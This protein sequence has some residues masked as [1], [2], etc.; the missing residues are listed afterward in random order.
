MPLQIKYEPQEL[1]EIVG[2]RQTIIALEAYL[3][4]EDRNHVIMLEGPYG[5]GKTVIAYIIANKLGCSE[6]DLMEIDAGSERGVATADALRGTIGFRPIQGKVKVYIIDEI[7]ATSSK[8]QESLLKTTGKPPRHVYFILCTT[9]PQK[10]NKGLLSRSTRFQTTKLPRNGILRLIKNVLKEE[11]KEVPNDVL[12]EIAK[13]ADGEPRSA[14]VMLDQI[15]DLDP[16]DMQE[17]IREAQIEEKQII[18]LCRSL[19]KGEK[20]AKVAQI[21]KS[22]TAEPEKTRYAVLG[23]CNSVL[24]GD[25]SPRAALIIDCFREPFYSSGKAGLSLACYNVIV[26]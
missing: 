4:K 15:I 11:K 10:I 23:Y 22:L 16:E 17:V 2:N 12:L 7:Q 21:L 19:I 5:T 18:D 25:A 3:K 14:L 13:V 26:G 20:W 1:S 8:F 24:L 9:D 6:F